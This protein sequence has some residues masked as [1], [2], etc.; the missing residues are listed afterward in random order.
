MMSLL[1]ELE[2]ILLG[3]FYKDVTPDGVEIGICFGRFGRAGDGENWLS[4]ARHQMGAPIRI[5][6]LRETKIL[7]SFPEG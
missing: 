3:V 4:Q 6:H 1:T 7:C 5:V 2:I